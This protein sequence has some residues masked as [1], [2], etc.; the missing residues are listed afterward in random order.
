MRPVFRFPVYQSVSDWLERL[1]E[2]R[3]PSLDELNAL[4]TTRPLSGGGAPIVFVEPNAAREPYETTVFR[5]GRVPTRTA[6]WHDVF[7]ARVW[8]SF[9]LTKAALNERHYEEL[10][11]HGSSGRRGTAR[12]VLS[13][14]DEGGVIVA[15]SDASLLELLRGFEWKRLF[16]ERRREARQQMRFLVFGHAILE[17]AL[18]PYKAVT[19]KALL[20][21]VPERFMSAPL[22]AQIAEADRH[23]ARWFA[24]REALSST[25][26][27]SPLPILGIPGWADNESAAF[28][29]DPQVF[30]PGYSEG[31]CGDQGNAGTVGSS[32]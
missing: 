15:S 3:F 9:P 11:I 22:E 2:D 12:D 17:K 10:E 23:A 25:R 24:S 6:N 27:L 7:N 29:D 21:E 16:W 1:P 20:L 4:A 13:L 30:R 31:R 5:T 8:L 18:Q 28:Y 14:F 19:A 26:S 32:P